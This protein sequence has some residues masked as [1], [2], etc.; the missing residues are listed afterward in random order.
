MIERAETVSNSVVGEMLN[1]QVCLR[2]LVAMIVVCALSACSG[3]SGGAIPSSPEKVEIPD[4]SFTIPT[5]ERWTTDN[6]IEVYYYHND[7]LP[8]IRGV[9]YFPGGSLSDYSGITGLAGAVGD[10]MR[11]GAFEGM[12]PDDLDRRLDSLAASIETDFGSEY[13][14]ASF[15]SLTEDFAEVFRLYADVIQR[16]AFD[17]SRLELWKK[18]VANSIVRR[19]DSPDKMA[20]M[21]FAEQIYGK[22]SPF[23]K[24]ID[25]DSLELITPERLREFH[26]RFVRPDGAKLAISGALSREEVEAAVNQHFGSWPVGRYVRPSLPSVDYTPKPGIYVLERDFDQATV[27]IGHQ[28]PARHTPDQ[29]DISIYN[30]VFGH[31]GF[32]ST[33]FKEIRSRLGLAYYVY[34]GISSG[35]V[36]G[37][38][39]MSMGTRSTQV[40]KAIKQAISLS[41][42]TKTELPDPDAFKDAKSAVKRSFVFKFASPDYIARRAVILK[43]L[44]YSEDYDQTYLANIEKVSREDLLAVAKK[45]VHPKELVVVVVG[46]VSAQEMANA[47]AGTA[48]VYRLDFD[49]VPR[50]VGHVPPLKQ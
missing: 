11:E 29:F 1:K 14:T 36:R 30:R 2:V 3:L 21:A 20:G 43:L 15:F 42:E 19:K 37:V 35:A 17:S 4:I 18:L 9:M 27:L 44:G 40:E 48:D 24:A 45:R 49:T 47:F 5:A 7:E 12:S 50:V 26:R 41:A 10:Q 8:Q 32:G 16:P 33:L 22:G 39:Q 23:A 46:R 34:G 6:G 31:G 38:F 28:G 25:A 13:G